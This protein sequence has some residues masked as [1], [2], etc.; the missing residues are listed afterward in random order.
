MD[1][2]VGSVGLTP[3]SIFDSIGGFI[4]FSDDKLDFVA[5]FLDQSTNYFSH[6]GTQSVARKLI[7]RAAEEI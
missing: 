5:A 6:T 7:L 2:L 3:Q 4:E 1:N